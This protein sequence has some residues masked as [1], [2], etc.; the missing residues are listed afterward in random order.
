MRDDLKDKEMTDT[1][2]ESTSFAGGSKYGKPGSLRGS[3]LELNQA[4]DGINPHAT[5]P[6]EEPAAS[7]TG[8][9][10]THL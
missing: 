9:A 4:A 8:A 2:S 3:T 6:E 5:I 1:A 10:G 7:A